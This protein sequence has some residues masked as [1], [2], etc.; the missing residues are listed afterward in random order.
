MKLADALVRFGVKDASRV[1]ATA[2]PLAR[3]LAGAGEKQVL[4]LSGDDLLLID[5]PA[6]DHH[7]VSLLER[8][9]VW[10]A[11]YRER[12]AGH[13]LVVSFPDGR[14]AAVVGF[15]LVERFVTQLDRIASRA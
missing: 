1:Y 8:V 4:A 14:S 12:F 9:K 13:Q 2:R 15:R 7:A 10:D 11:S 3:R 5:V 6:W